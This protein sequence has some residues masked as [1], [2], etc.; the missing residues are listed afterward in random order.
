MKT[1]LLPANNY[2]VTLITWKNGIP[3][4]KYGKTE[5]SSHMTFY[6]RQGNVPP[7]FLSNKIISAATSVKYLGLI[8]DKHYIIKLYH[9]IIKNIIILL[10]ILNL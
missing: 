2:K 4:G 8:L 5:K 7:P 6:L 1:H 3:N 9:Y 10:Y